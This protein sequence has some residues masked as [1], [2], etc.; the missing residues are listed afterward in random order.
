MGKEPVMYG[1]HTNVQCIAVFNGAEGA[2]PAV[3]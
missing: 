2:K 1:E 3:L